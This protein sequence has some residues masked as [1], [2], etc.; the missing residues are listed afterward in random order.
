MKCYNKHLEE[1]LQGISNLAISNEEIV[2]FLQLLK[3][4][5]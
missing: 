1:E 2:E 4:Q 3:G 5:K